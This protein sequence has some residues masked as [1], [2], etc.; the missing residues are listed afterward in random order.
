MW[1]QE[2]ARR[3]VFTLLIRNDAAHVIQ[4]AWH[5]SQYQD[6]QK[7]NAATHI[8]R[9]FRGYC[10]RVEYIVDVLDIIAVQSCVRRFIALQNYKLIKASFTRERRVAATCIQ[11]CWRWKKARDASLE[12]KHSVYRKLSAIVI[13]SLVRSWIARTKMHQV[14]YEAVVYQCTINIQSMWRTF[15]CRMVL[16]LLRA[17]RRSTLAA[18]TI[19]AMTRRYLAKSYSM[20]LK[21]DA[22]VYKSAELIQAMW[23]GKRSRSLIGVMHFASTII[24]ST[25]RRSVSIC[26]FHIKRF[27]AVVIQSHWRRRAA[28]KSFQ[29]IVLTIRKVQNSC[30]R[31]LA[32]TK[33]QRRKIIV[34]KIQSTWRMW[35]ALKELQR[36]KHFR[37]MY[38][39]ATILVQRI[40]RGYSIKNTFKLVKR[41]AVV[42]QSFY[43]CYH[44]CR[45]FNKAKQATVTAQSVIRQFLA[46]KQLLRLVEYRIEIER[47]RFNATVRIQAMFRGAIDRSIL[48][49]RHCSA[50]EIQRCIRGTL[51]KVDIYRLVCCII[52]V[53]SVV[54]RWLACRT[55]CRRQDAIVRIQALARKFF[56]VG[57]RRSLTLVQQ[58]A[59]SEHSATLAIQSLHRGRLGRHMAL[60]ESSARKIQ[61][62]WRCYTVHVE[63]M[64]SILAAIDIQA[65]VRR[66][67]AI[68]HYKLRHAAIVCL[69]SF[70]RFALTKIKQQ[71]EIQCATKLQS[72]ARMVNFRS[73][74]VRQK[75]EYENAILIQSYYRRYLSRSVNLRLHVATTTLQR[76]ARGFLLRL[77]LETEGFAAVEIQRI[78][79]GFTA[80]EFFAWN[81][82]AAIKLQSYFRREICKS[83]TKQIKNG[84]IA[85]RFLAAKSATKIQLCYRKYRQHVRDISAATMIQ[86]T[87][88]RFLSQ[89]MFSKVRR[90]ILKT[91]CL[92]RGF[93]VR[94]NRST[95]LRDQARRIETANEKALSNPNMK[96]GYRTRDS[97]NILVN[98]KSLAEIIDA[99][100]VLEVATRLSEVCC[101]TIADAAAPDILFSVIQ[102]CNRSLPHLKLLQ[103]ILLTLSN[104]ARF[105]KL[106]PTMASLL[107]VEVFLDLVQMFRDK[108][109][110][111][112]LV[113]SL[114]DRI[115]RSNIPKMVR[116]HSGTKG[117]QFSC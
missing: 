113:V 95:Q 38:M 65:T 57:E 48:R 78:W 92:V 117:R 26:D 108:D 17:N 54:R 20:E 116:F 25:W 114:L 61:K 104:V 83:L 79:L 29:Q 4:K 7:N 58:K 18:I 62:T 111:F 43:R 51:V 85:D 67:Q 74:L 76:Y 28:T 102:T 49:H 94:Q 39:N 90:G 27:C 53:Q 2:L 50:I 72:F 93:I 21:Y 82:L 47:K 41:D 12:M 40:W 110:I 14:K 55:V 86:R 44:T 70:T 11:C 101:T 34:C 97:L 46:Q 32:K 69:Q 89:R 15:K 68:Y 3:Q 22:L 19:Q 59:V 98:S 60:R 23:R 10:R 112:C 84:N 5:A 6:T 88:K 77:Q 64:L 109:Y 63:Y 66:F 106:V 16:N 105:D 31:F 24:Q 9:L 99:T 81:V 87:A 73:I 103:Y 30:R 13:Q 100:C 1:R 71:R 107:G 45:H 56:A 33:Y 80:R 91:Q 36:L 75:V 96:L 37:T 35:S 8:Q 52:R 115:I 42:I